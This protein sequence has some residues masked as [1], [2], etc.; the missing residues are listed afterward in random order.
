MP[1][2]FIPIIV[3]GLIGKAVHTRFKKDKPLSV[4]QQNIYD[5]AMATLME[6][7]KL[8]ALGATFKAQGFPKHGQMLI[9]RAELRGLDPK[10][11]KARRKAIAKA[12]NSTNIVAIRELAA[13]YEK[14]GGTGT[15]DMLRKR[16]NQVEASQK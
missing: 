11:Y 3:I 4:E 7:E 2:P 12:M 9:N 13:E 5:S 10:V 15:A 1:I 6:P 8:R 16:A 14:L